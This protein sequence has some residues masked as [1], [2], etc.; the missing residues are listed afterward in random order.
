[1]ANEITG[2]FNLRIGRGSYVRQFD[3]NIEAALPAVAPGIAGPQRIGTIAEPVIMGDVV[4]AGIAWF[5]NVGTTEIRVGPN[6]SP[7]VPFLSIPA[8]QTCGPLWLGSD[9]PLAV[10]IGGNGLLDYFIQDR[11]ETT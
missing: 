10:S 3:R 5:Q 8:G 11:G 7:F 4:D 2:N 1:M 9:D 6:T